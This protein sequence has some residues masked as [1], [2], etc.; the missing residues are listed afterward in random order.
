M[1]EREKRDEIRERARATA[2]EKNEI[3]PSRITSLVLIL[4]LAVTRKIKQTLERKKKANMI[5]NQ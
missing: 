1:R 5:G 4:S 2:T 3:K